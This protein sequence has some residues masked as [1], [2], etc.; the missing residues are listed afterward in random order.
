MYVK[1]DYI[2]P[3]LTSARAGKKKYKRQKQD[4]YRCKTMDSSYPGLRVI[5][6]LSKNQKDIKKRNTVKEE[7]RRFR[8]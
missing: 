2:I 5:H 8:Y 7:G 4:L 1:G 6:D 3:P